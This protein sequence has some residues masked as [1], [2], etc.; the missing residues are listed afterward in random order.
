MSRP[1]RLRAVAGSEW[2]RRSLGVAAH[3][4]IELVVTAVE[5]HSIARA[6]H[7]RCEPAL[8]EGVESFAS[9]VLRAHRFTITGTL[10][11]GAAGKT[12]VDGAPANLTAGGC[13][14]VTAFAAV[15]RG[16]AVVGTVAIGRAPAATKG[17]ERGN[18]AHICEFPE[19]PAH[20][21]LGASS[22]PGVAPGERTSLSYVTSAHRN[23]HTR[24]ASFSSEVIKE[25][26]R[27]RG[28]PRTFRRA[29][30]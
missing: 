9:F 30:E 23:E 8:Q 15:G 12:N 5:G 28:R 27:K 14:C 16:R 3:D 10:I 17:E 21:D 13:R 4:A 1:P 2:T 26:A 19:Q 29:D 18:C 22:R 7:R 24:L 20:P 11:D 25:S 6:Q